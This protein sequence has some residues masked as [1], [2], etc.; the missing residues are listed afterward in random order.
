[1][2]SACEQNIKDLSRIAVFLEQTLEDE[3]SPVDNNELSSNFSYVER[4]GIYGVLC[5]MYAVMDASNA[6]VTNDITRDVMMDLYREPNSA[7]QR[8]T[9]DY[10]VLRDFSK[11]LNKIHQQ[12][13]Y[14]AQSDVIIRSRTFRRKHTSLLKSVH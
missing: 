9:R 10:I 3:R 8:Y 4:Q 7:A 1:V 5:P 13:A 2:V 11:L 12:Y 6:D 14:L